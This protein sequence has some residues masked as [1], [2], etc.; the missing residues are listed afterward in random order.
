MSTCLYC[1]RPCP[2]APSL[3]VCG[4]CYEIHC[5]HKRTTLYKKDGVEVCDDCS[6]VLRADL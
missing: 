5:Q 2:G 3:R 1:N 4:D 6:F